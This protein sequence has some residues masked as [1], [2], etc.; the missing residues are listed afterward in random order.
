MLANEIEGVIRHSENFTNVPYDRFI[1]ER[2]G[3]RNVGARTLVLGVLHTLWMEKYG[4]LDPFFS[5]MAEHFYRDRTT[6][7]Y[8]M[9]CHRDIIER[10]EAGRGMAADLR[11]LDRYNKLLEEARK[12]VDMGVKNE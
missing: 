5:Y 11:Y 3:Y 12:I 10:I 8:Y 4:K 2:R 9:D 7:H 6:L 1:S